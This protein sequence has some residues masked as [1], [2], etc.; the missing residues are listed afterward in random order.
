MTGWTAN[1]MDRVTGWFIAAVLLAGLV[2]VSLQLTPSSYA[3]VLKQIDAPADAGPL[4]GEERAVRSDEWAGVTPMFQASVRARFQRIN[5]TSV[6]REDLRNF[7]ALPLR[8]WGLAFK[9]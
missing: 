6:Y 9:P 2:Y 3:V 7:Y 8:D 5:E 1:S 4:M